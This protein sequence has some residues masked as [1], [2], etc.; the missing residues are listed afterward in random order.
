MLIRSSCYY[1]WPRETKRQAFR[2]TLQKVTFFYLILVYISSI[3]SI[4]FYIGFK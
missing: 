3:A 1:D 2:A 4:L